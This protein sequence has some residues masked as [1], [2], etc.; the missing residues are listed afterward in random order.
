[1]QREPADYFPPVFLTSRGLME[2]SP[3]SNPE[4]LERHPDAV[5]DPETL[6]VA[7]GQPIRQEAAWLT[8]AVEPANRE[9]Y[10]GL[11]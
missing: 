11:R 5:N 1:M 9:P 4:Y 6:N 2:K 8:Q 7:P 3:I 10:E